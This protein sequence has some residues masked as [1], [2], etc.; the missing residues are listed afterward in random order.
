MKIKIL[1]VI[2]FLMGTVS[3]FA[4]DTLREG[5][6][7]YV[8]D[9][10]G[11]TQSLESTKIKGESYVEAHLTI[12]SGTDLRKMYQKIFSKER[13]TELSD[14]VLICLVQFNA[15]TQK[16]SHVVFSPLDNKMRL[17]LTELKRL[18]MGFKSL[19]Y[20]YWIVNNTKVDEFSLFTIPIKFR[21]I[22]GED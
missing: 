2:V 9:I 5:N 8:T 7:V 17:T 6:L 18:E 21:R 1:L 19:K 16:I 15:I 12:S 22:Y 14:Y 11:V 4:Q 3:V 13:A 20:N 10:N